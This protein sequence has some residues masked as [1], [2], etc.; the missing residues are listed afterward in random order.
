MGDIGVNT[1]R[2]FCERLRVEN[3]QFGTFTLRYRRA[4]FGVTRIT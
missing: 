3:P 1:Q 2:D 4:L